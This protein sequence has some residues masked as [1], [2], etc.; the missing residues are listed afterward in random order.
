[1]SITAIL[2]RLLGLE[3][4]QRIVSAQP[5]FGAPWAH[6]APAWVLFGLLGLA[7]VAAVFYARYQRHRSAPARAALTALRAAALGLLLVMLAEPVVEVVYSHQRR[8]VLWLLLDGT[9]SMA[10]VDTYSGPDRDRLFEAVGLPAIDRFGGEGATAVA[11]GN[12]AA[13]PAGIDPGAPPSRADLVKAILQKDDGKLLRDL[14]ENFRLRAFLFD[15]VEGVRSLDATSGPRRDIDPRRLAGQITADG[16]VTAL[17]AAFRDL[18]R[19]H[20]TSHLAGLVVFSD[21]DQNAGPPAMAA[22]RELGVPIYAAG[23][24]PVAAADLALS[25]QAPL[26]VKKDEMGTVTVTIRQQGFDGQSVEVRLSAGQA[27]EEEAAATAFDP[28]DERTVLL[29]GSIQQVEFPYVPE[30]AGRFTLRAEVEPLP[31]EVVEENNVARRDITVLDDFLRLLFVEYEPT[32]EWRFIKEVFHRD[33]LVGMQGFRTFL[34][35]SDPR[36]RQTSEMFLA[37]MRPPRSEFFE[38]DV[39]F[40]GDVP[41]S[42]LS[43]RF[44]EMA[45]EFVRRFGGGLVVMAG[46]RFGVGQLADTPLADL[47]PVVISPGAR[48]N[49]RQPFRLQLTPQATAYD[50]MRLGGE[51]ESEHRR[52]WD[53]LGELPWYQPVERVHPMAAA[54]VLAEHPAATCVDGRTK[55]PLVAIRRVGR[56]EVVYLGFNE[57]WRLRRMHGE[58]YYRQFWGQLIHRLGL[59]HAL[60]NQKRFVV[61]TD[62]QRYRANDEVVLTVEAYDADYEPL[63][64]EALPG[65]RLV[66][67][68]ILPAA[69]ADQPGGVQS[70]SA[71]MVRPGVYEARFPVFAHGEHRVRVADPVVGKPVDAVFHVAA[72]S[73][74]RQSAV[75]DVALQ[76][77]IAGVHPGGRSYDLTTVARLPKEINLE[78]KTELSVEVVALWNTWLCFTL[79]LGALL[80]EWLLR[81]WV[82]LT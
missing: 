50:F 13:A 43:P 31:G 58:K 25:V 36:V 20:A 2:G 7:A 55:Q 30:R 72:V 1:M 80:G 57:T 75:R 71:P 45:D 11:S 56:G 74:E 46:P 70:V 22:A 26:H 16:E 69:S 82:N 81:K 9:E 47:L 5:S 18:G 41:A 66:A 73:V 52:A 53:N 42:A 40:L 34:H 51:S 3:D 15:R 49:D 17:G 62:R 68:L 64:E 32:W 63:A 29:E 78:A 79:V 67:E 65:Q 61:D 10:I 38:Y 33:K 59:S 4:P 28:I 39:I 60:G 6:D 76:E 54:G 37:T 12:P 8:P 77:Q 35:S 23:V 21:F 44:C 27:G 19:R 14:A 24:G 48:I